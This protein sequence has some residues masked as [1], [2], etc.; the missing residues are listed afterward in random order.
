MRWKKISQ[1]LSMMC[2]RHAN[3]DTTEQVL[4]CRVLLMRSSLMF[5]LCY[6]FSSFVTSGFEVYISFVVDV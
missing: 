5:E 1:K 3:S 2:I 4:G 6:R